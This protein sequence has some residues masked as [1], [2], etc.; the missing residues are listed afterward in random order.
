MK[1]LLISPK[2]GTIRISRFTAADIQPSIE[3]PPQCR[4]VEAFQDL[5]RRCVAPLRLSKALQARLASCAARTGRGVRQ[6]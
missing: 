6:R 5:D 3:F 4:A 2:N 1:C